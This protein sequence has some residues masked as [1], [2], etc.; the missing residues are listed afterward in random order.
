MP[1]TTS[2]TKLT[3]AWTQLSSG[4]NTKTISVFDG[5]VYIAD[6]T[7]QPAADFTGHLVQVGDLAWV[8]TPPSILWARAAGNSATVVVSGD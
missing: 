1:Q 5:D 6:S 7:A 2:N 4:T 8:A 3:R